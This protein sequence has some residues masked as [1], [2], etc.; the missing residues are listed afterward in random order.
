MEN[1][2]AKWNEFGKWKHEMEIRRMALVGHRKCGTE[3]GV[4][5]FGRLVAC[6][7]RKRNR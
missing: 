2:S 4:S 7:G 3:P 1:G 6:S 5:L